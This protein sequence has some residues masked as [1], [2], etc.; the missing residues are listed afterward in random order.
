MYTLNIARAIK[1]K[2]VNE[3]RDFIFEIYYT[4]IGFSKEDC[5]YLLKRLKRKNL[6]LPS[7]KLI[8]KMPDPR[9]A[10]EHYQSFL[11]KKNR[12]SL[13]RPEIFTYQL[14]TF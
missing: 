1:K 12:K 7:N 4:R 2:S 3:I 14:K 8:E 9:N 11:R 6:L 5:Y 13:K 10:K